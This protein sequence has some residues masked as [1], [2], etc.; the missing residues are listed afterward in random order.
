MPDQSLKQLRGVNQATESKLA[1]LGIHNLFD[2]VFHF[3]FRYQDRT[4]LTPIAD[5]VPGREALVQGEIIDS[6]LLFYG[7][8]GLQLSLQDKSGAMFIKFFYHSFALK[9]SMKIGSYLRC[10]GTPRYGKKA[11]DMVHPECSFISRDQPLDEGLTPVYPLTQGISQRKMRSIIAQALRK[12]K[13]NDLPGFIDFNDRGAEESGEDDLSILRC[14][15]LIH[16]PPPDADISSLMNGTHSA[17]YKLAL[18]ELTAHRLYLLRQKQTSKESQAPRIAPATDRWREFVATL[19][20]SPT[21]GQENACV[22]IGKDLDKNRQMVR[23]VQGD[24][25][26]GKTLVA[27]YAAL[28]A[29]TANWQTAL[30]APTEILAEQHLNQFTEWFLPMGLNIVPLIGKMS[31]K[32]KREQQEIIAKGYAD[33]VIGTHA[34]FQESVKFAKLGLII[35]DEQQ[36]FGVK[37][38]HS[39]QEKGMEQGIFPHQLI[40]SATPIPRTL[41][42]TIMANMDITSIMDMPPGRIPCETSLLHSGRRGELLERLKPHLAKD[43]QVYWVCPL[44]DESDEIPAE[45]V[46][47]IEKQLKE[48]LPDYSLTVAHGRQKA[49]AKSAA[50]RDFK[51]GKSQVLVA[52][53]VIEVGVDVPN[54][55]FMV[56]ENAERMGLGQL[57]QLR[58]RVGRGGDKSYCILMY[59]E[60]LSE[61]A[62]E[63][64]HIMTTSNS[65]FEIAETDLR[66]RGAGEIIGTRQSG[67]MQF[68]VAD[69]FKHKG[70]INKSEEL[71][72]RLL[73]MPHDHQQRLIS[74]WINEEESFGAV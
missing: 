26:C 66:L 13:E 58:G 21:P 54:A 15:R 55:N 46:G 30:M 33:L 71:S 73:S 43:A 35:V 27:A 25:G 64:L 29:A 10:Y 68:K 50:M 24:V 70:I 65:G 42:Q 6:K 44:I 7:K 61:T 16:S 59:N 52:T 56:I 23:L 57:H 72:N 41:A 28:Q 49:E 53:T 20:F 69:L 8:K 31:A 37:Q 5:L 39:L 34:L 4:H 47:N 60:P 22:E 19:P 14:L 18:E 17:Q 51:N 2:L 1:N 67:A 63:R 9:K 48:A 12:I 74:R 36:R 3:P 38:R 40:M 32:V 45:N 11:L 62:K